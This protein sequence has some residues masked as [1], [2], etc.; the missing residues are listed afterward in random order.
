MQVMLLYESSIVAPGATTLLDSIILL[1][2]I[3]QVD[4]TFIHL[5]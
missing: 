4:V 3:K 1:L 5:R 2:V